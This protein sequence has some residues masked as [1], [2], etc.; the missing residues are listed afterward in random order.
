MRVRFIVLA[1]PPR[2]SILNL[3]PAVEGKQREKAQ[4]KESDWGMNFDDIHSL[5]KEYKMSGDHHKSGAHKDAEGHTLNKQDE[6]IADWAGRDKNKDI[7]K[8]I[9]H[10]EELHRKKVVHKQAK[11]GD[12]GP[13]RTKSSTH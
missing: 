9:A 8:Q 6:Y 7:E 4:N 5:L 10:A 3:I 2:Q 12:H 11:S 1:A 13:G